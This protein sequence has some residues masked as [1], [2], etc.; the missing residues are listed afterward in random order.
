[1]LTHLPYKAKMN[2]KFG[3][4]GTNQF[5]SRFLKMFRPTFPIA[6]NLGAHI[7][8]NNTTFVFQFEYIVENAKLDFT[9]LPHWNMEEEKWKT[10]VICRV[11]RFQEFPEIRQTDRQADRRGV[12]MNSPNGE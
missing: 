11:D 5:K 10:P 1:M 7:L 9:E 6:S 2:N 12:D 8:E 4:P 3:I